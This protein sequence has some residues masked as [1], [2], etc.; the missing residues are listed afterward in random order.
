MNPGR[1]LDA[2]IAEKVM[3]ACRL[4]GNF[5]QKIDKDN[6]SV[7]IGTEWNYPPYSTD[8][9]AAWT[10][11]ERLVERG[12]EF[13][14]QVIKNGAACEFKDTA[15][16]IIYVGFSDKQFHQETPYA[17]CLAALRAV[18]HETK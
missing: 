7:T 13:K 1:E 17:I 4:E 2:L 6:K 10:L 9:S 5:V 8:I 18:G 15:K 16:K 11:I 3:S 12:L 14:L